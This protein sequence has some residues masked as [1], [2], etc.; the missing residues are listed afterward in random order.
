MKKARNADGSVTLT[1]SAEE[2]AKLTEDWRE[3]ERHFDMGV[4]FDGDKNSIES[5]VKEANE[6]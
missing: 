6:P 2:L 1:L 3:L 4:F 5:L